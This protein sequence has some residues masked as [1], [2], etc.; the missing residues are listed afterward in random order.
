MA[1]KYLD[2][3]LIEKSNDELIILRKLLFIRLSGAA[4]VFK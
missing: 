2:S 3:G 1:G 4:V